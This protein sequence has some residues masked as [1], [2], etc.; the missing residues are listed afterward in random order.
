MTSAWKTKPRAFVGCTLLVLALGLLRPGSVQP[1]P[2]S[3]GDDPLPVTILFT[4]DIESAFDPTP[5]YWRS[6]LELIGGVAQLAT[7]IEVQRATEPNVFLFDSGDIFTGT[8]SKLTRGE[9]PFELMLTMGYDAMCIGN[10]EFEYGWETF[11]TLKNRVSFPVLGANLFYKGTQIPYTQPYTVFERN[12]IRLAVIGILG[13]D[14][15]TALI[16]SNIAGVDVLDPIPILTRL[17]PELR[18]DVD[19]VVLLTHQ[20]DTAPM[21]TDDEWRPEIQRDITADRYV[22]GKVPGIDVLL[23]GHADAGTRTPVVHP[24]TGT[25][26]MQTFGQAQHLGVL[27]LQLNRMTRQIERFEGKLL[28]VDSNK[29]RPNETVWTKLKTY[30]NQFPEM[31]KPVG[32]TTQRINRQYNQ[33]SDLGNLFA[34]ILRSH[35]G[36]DIGLM[37][38]GALRKDLPKGPVTRMDLLDAFPFTDR[39]AIVELTGRTLRNIVEQGLSLERGMLQVSGMTV[40]YDPGAQALNRAIEIKVAGVV[41]SDSSRYQVA[42]I[43]ILAAGGDRYEQF[44]EALQVSYVESTYADALQQYFASVGVVELPPRGR[45][46]S[47]P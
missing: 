29:L 39:I 46:N 45:L 40:T 25:I 16:P 35:T 43:E 28:D 2:D 7:L 33:E 15:A 22:A 1:A 32:R 9:L 14:A 12:G 37:P 17:V 4:N 44:N 8:L 18:Q 23:G 10:H 34:D 11:A 41:L 6:D 42:T 27:Q 21:Q 24:V 19:L 13:Q 3:Q 31:L 26:I 20:G 30:R 38:S 36:A 47:R 5:A